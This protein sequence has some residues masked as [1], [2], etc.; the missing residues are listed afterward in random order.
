MHRRTFFTLPAIAA[1]LGPRFATA[2]NADPEATPVVWAT[3]PLF[4]IA[5]IGRRGCRIV[6]GVSDP[7]YTGANAI[8]RTN[9]AG[10]IE[11]DPGCWLLVYAEDDS[12][13]ERLSHALAPSLCERVF[14]SSAIALTVARRPTSRRRVTPLPGI[15]DP[16]D[17]VLRFTPANSIDPRI[18]V[19]RKLARALRAITGLYS[20]EAIIGC[21]L[22]DLYSA[23]HG[24]GDAWIGRGEATI[25]PGAGRIATERALRELVA[26]EGLWRKAGGMVALIEG[27]ESMGLRGF[28]DM[29]E[30]VCDYTGNL[31]SLLIL[32]QCLFRGQRTDTAVTVLVAA[33]TK[34]GRGRSACRD[35][36]NRKGEPVRWIPAEASSIATTG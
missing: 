8:T 16:F 11:A 35:R 2:G 18:D 26:D 4:G 6:A 29:S 1:L 20:P 13:A 22:A 23:F 32:M 7:A 33:E 25:G 28:A 36:T 9:L 14:A 15:P 34:N 10:C 21:D 12:A 17:S 5:G 24:A 30:F 27:P 31:D 3:T 19:E